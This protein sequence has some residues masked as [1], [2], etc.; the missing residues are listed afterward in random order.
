[1]QFIRLTIAGRDTHVHIRVDTIR[2]ISELENGGP[3]IRFV[4]HGDSYD[5][6]EPA[7]FIVSLIQGASSIAAN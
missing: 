7:D 3:R 4:H 1:M 6:S 5:V 2:M